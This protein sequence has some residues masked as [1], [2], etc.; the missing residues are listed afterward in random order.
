MVLIAS[1]IVVQ[2][3]QNVEIARKLFPD[4]GAYITSIWQYCCTQWSC[5]LS[6]SIS[7]IGEKVARPNLHVMLGFTSDAGLQNLVKDMIV[8]ERQ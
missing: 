1:E 7:Y 3:C 4:C 5:V 2:L 8:S 6:S